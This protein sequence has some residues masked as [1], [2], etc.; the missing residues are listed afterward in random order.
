MKS[1]NVLCPQSGKFIDL[2]EELVSIANTYKIQCDE[3]L[4][5]YN[6]RLNII[7]FTIL[8]S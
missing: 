4:E 2:S 6:K 1:I 3:N 7:Q 8:T 5:I